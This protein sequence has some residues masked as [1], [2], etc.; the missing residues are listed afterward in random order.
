MRIYPAI[1]LNEPYISQV[2]YGIKTVETRMRRLSQLT[3]DVVFCCDKGILKGSTFAGKAVCLVNVGEMRAMT[4][5]DAKAACIENAPG[6]IAYPLSNLRHFSYMFDVKDYAVTRNWQGIF[7]LQVP[8]FV[9]I[10]NLK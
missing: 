4:D 3:G 5:H 2:Y 10:I 8:D 1:I 6:R 7:Q 9:E